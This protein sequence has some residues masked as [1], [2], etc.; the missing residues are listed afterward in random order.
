MIKETFSIKN[1]Y[2]SFSFIWQNNKGWFMSL[3]MYG[4]VQPSHGS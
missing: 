4:H 2:K 1:K 3:Y